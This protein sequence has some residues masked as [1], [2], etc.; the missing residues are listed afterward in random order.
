MDWWTCLRDIVSNG[1]MAV[2]S[3]ELVRMLD[4]I[5]WNGRDFQVTCVY[6]QLPPV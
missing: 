1:E 5:P 2:A 3:S 6:R 4:E